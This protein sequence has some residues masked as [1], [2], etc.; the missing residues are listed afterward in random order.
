MRLAGTPLLL[1]DV[2]EVVRSIRGR[3]IVGGAGRRNDVQHRRGRLCRSRRGI[4]P[5]KRAAML[6]APRSL[7]PTGRSSVSSFSAM[8]IG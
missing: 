4:L 3:D 1:G 2:G 5:A 8:M 6:V 7:A